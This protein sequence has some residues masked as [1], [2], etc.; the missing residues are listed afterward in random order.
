MHDQ[1]AHLQ[2]SA[3]GLARSLDRLRRDLLSRF[4]RLHPSSQPIL[5]QENNV[6]AFTGTSL[7]LSPSNSLGDAARRWQTPPPTATNVT[8]EDVGRAT[9][10]VLHTLAAQYPDRP[11]RQQRRDA[12]TLIDV[13]TRLYPCG[14]C[15]RHFREVVAA[16]PPRVGNKEEFSQWMCRVH[17]VVNRSLGKPTFNCDYVDARWSGVECG[18]GNA[19]VL[20]IGRGKPKR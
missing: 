10:L 20:D 17:N 12:R 2:R 8:R 3:D 18:E 1:L 6:I 11:T 15:A 13:L 16:N 5:P 4:P 14:E 19:C 9:W 7:P